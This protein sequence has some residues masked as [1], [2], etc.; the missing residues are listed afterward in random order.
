V[1]LGRLIE[2]QK[3][4]EGRLQW[5]IVQ[6]LARFWSRYLLAEKIR[7]TPKRTRSCAAIYGQPTRL[8]DGEGGGI[9]PGYWSSARSWQDGAFR[10]AKSTRRVSNCRCLTF[11]VAGEDKMKRVSGW[12][13]LD[14]MFLACDAWIQRYA[15]SRERLDAQEC[16]FCGWEAAAEGEDVDNAAHEY[17]SKKYKFEDDVCDAKRDFCMGYNAGFAWKERAKAA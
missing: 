6:G 17:A 16:F 9:K 3:R 1:A 8:R 10:G 5:A 14:A 11:N 7:A 2:K 13:E 4:H 15:L 12:E